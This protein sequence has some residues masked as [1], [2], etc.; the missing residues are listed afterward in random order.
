MA[1]IRKECKKVNMLDPDIFFQ[2]RNK[3]FRK[4]TKR[5][6]RKLQV[7]LKHCLLA[8]A[9]NLSERGAT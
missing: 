1:S 4:V 5:N 2:E 7:S 9:I 8:Y 3:Y 6:I